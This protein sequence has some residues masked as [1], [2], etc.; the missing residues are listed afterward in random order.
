M[1]NVKQIKAGNTTY[2]IDAKYWNGSSSIKTINGTSLLG[3]GNISTT[4]TLKT[5]NG[6]TLLGS[7]NIL[8][9]DN[10]FTCNT[11]PEI[12][13]KITNIPNDFFADGRTFWLYF[14]NGSRNNGIVVINNSDSTFSCDLKLKGVL[15]GVNNGITTSICVYPGIYELLCYNGFFIFTGSYYTTYPEPYIL[16]TTQQSSISYVLV[17]NTNVVFSG[18]PLESL[19]IDNASVSNC[20]FEFVSYGNAPTL[21]CPSTWTW[22]NGIPRIVGNKRYQV[23]V[24]NNCAIIA[25]FDNLN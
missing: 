7:G 23:S 8:T 6:K 16:V 11:S 22:A 25:E 15:G 24:K 1:A 20:S 10:I 4:P 14:R 21:T 3:S 17:D 13:Q 2:D 9:N 18:T 5:I 12:Q 19:T